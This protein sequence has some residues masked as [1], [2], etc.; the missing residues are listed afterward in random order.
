MIINPGPVD[1]VAGVPVTRPTALGAALLLLVVGG[2]LL[3]LRARR[4][5]ALR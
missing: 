2:G 1:T 3:Y 4:R 5:A